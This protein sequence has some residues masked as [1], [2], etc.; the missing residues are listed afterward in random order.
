MLGKDEEL[1]KNMQLFLEDN[2][3]SII[4]KIINLFK[5]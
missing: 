3:E 5:T 1:N 4:P 2:E